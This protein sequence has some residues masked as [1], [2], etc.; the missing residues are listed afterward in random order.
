MIYNV[1]SEIPIV[2]LKEGLMN[3]EVEEIPVLE[4]NQLGKPNQAGL[5]LSKSV[6]FILPG[7]ILVEKYF[8][9]T[10]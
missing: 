5:I 1:P 8:Y 10:N 7:S 6:L 9:L 3:A 2:D 4:A